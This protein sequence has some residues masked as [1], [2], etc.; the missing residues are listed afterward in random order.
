MFRVCRDALGDA[1]RNQLAEHF[2]AVN[3]GGDTEAAGAFALGRIAAAAHLPALG[4]RHTDAGDG[5]N[6][7][8]N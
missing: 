5:G 1:E 7:F 3:A 4:N 6:L 8:H 2:I